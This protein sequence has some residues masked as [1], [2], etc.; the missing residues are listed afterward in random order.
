MFNT[1]VTISMV[2]YMYPMFLKFNHHEIGFMVEEKSEIEAKGHR[3]ILPAYHKERRG[4]ITWIMSNLRARNN[5]LKHADAISKFI[6]VSCH[7]ISFNAIEH[8]I[9]IGISQNNLIK[10]RG[11]SYYVHHALP[12]FFERWWLAVRFSSSF[13]NAK[14]LWLLRL[15]S[16]W[17]VQGFAF[18]KSLRSTEVDTLSTN[19]ASLNFVFSNALSLL[20]VGTEVSHGYNLQDALLNSSLKLSL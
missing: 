13:L 2:P 7:L 1:Y 20:H 4:L 5:R 14:F 16:T 15:P 10:S 18:W 17:L 12:Y 19:Y 11:T 9:W 8:T 3:I 6:P